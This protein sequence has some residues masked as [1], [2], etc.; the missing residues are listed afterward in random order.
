MHFRS[1]RD[2]DVR[3]KR[4]LLREDLNVPMKDG[5]IADE[6]RIDAALPTLRWLRDRGA[7]TV[8]LSH[9]GRPDGQAEPEVLAAPDRGAARRAARHR[10]CASSTTASA[11][12][13]SPRRARWPTAGSRCSRTCA[14]TREEEANDPAF[15]R[16]LAASGDLYVNDAFGT[17]HRAHA[18]TA[19]VAA[20]L[21]RTRAF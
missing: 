13:P 10:T 15:A 21:P 7:K 18:S 16:E 20:Y 11:R 3:G 9:L 19:G 14:F 17:A 12:P 8:I 4:V 2:A 6:T 1:L 5:A